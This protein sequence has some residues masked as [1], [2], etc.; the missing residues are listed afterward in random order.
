M[1][2]HTGSA[3]V[4]GGGGGYAPSTQANDEYTLVRGKGCTAAA[5]DARWRKRRTHACGGVGCAGG[6]GVTGRASARGMCH[7][8]RNQGPQRDRA[9]AGVFPRAGS[10]RDG[11]ATCTAWRRRGGAPRRV[12]PTR[13]RPAKRRYS[14]GEASPRPL[15]QV[16]RRLQSSRRRSQPARLDGGHERLSCRREWC[17]STARSKPLGRRSRSSRPRACGRRRPRG[18]GGWA[19]H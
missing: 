11:G 8:L 16:R 3:G 14:K 9:R 13:P 19:R 2:L 10:E 15:A 7:G 6:L 1:V 18:R 4:G 5:G 17:T 12:L